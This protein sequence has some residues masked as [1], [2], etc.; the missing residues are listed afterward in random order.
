MTDAAD[1]APEGLSDETIEPDTK[2]WTWVLNETCP[3]CGYE[4]W[5]MTVDRFAPIVRDNA[6]VW[7]RLLADEGARRR[8]RPD[9]WSPLEY[10]AHVRDVHLVFAERIRLMLAEDEPRFANW[11]QD[12][13]A[14]EKAYHLA[15][16]AV[17]ATELLEAATAVADLYETVPP[18][19]WS[20]R[21]LRSNGSEFSVET[22]G[23]YHLHDVVHHRWDV[24]GTGWG[25]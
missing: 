19:A 4:A 21:G 23:R 9:A 5:S 10:G 16:P 13:T 8:P 20:R 22:L 12:A 15:D 2:D 7:E 3:E 14:R 17:V 1:T 18:D 11:D 25:A 6:T 24:D